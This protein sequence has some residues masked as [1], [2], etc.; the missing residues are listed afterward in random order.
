GGWGSWRRINDLQIWV[1]KTNTKTKP[2]LP[3][4]LLK[5]PLSGCSR[6]LELISTPTQIV[7]ELLTNQVPVTGP[8]SFSLN[9]LIS[10]NLSTD[11]PRL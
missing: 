9:L 10:R 11:Y 3:Y 7:N 2:D 4:N 8:D 5:S 6:D 1:T